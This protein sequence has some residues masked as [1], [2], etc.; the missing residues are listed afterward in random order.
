[1]SLDSALPT[2]TPLVLNPYYTS[3]NFF[4]VATSN[5]AD[6]KDI[7]I[8]GTFISSGTKYAVMYREAST[9]NLR[10]G[11][12][13]TA[14]GNTVTGL[15]N[16]DVEFANAY[17][18]SLTVSGLTAN[19]MIATDASKNLTV[20]TKLLTTPAYFSAYCTYTG[21]TSVTANAWVLMSTKATITMPTS[22]ANFTTSTAIANSGFKYT[23]APAIVQLSMTIITASSSLYCGI[24]TG[25]ATPAAPA[26][27]NTRRVNVSQMRNDP[28]TNTPLYLDFITLMNTNDEIAIY[29]LS[30][31]TSMNVG[32]WTI[33]GTV[34]G[35]T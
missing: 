16:A 10:V 9:G 1:M 26:D 28:R 32:T 6:A 25:V 29:I 20:A 19:S 3:T 5:A 35:Y 15:T 2:P 4:E 18:N 23:G 8:S 31:T 14:P 13:S 7:G 11:T 27:K 34:L 33:T 12:T 24:T 17:L 22:T 30:E 21:S